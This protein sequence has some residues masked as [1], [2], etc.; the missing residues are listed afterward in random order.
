MSFYCGIDLGAR[1]SQICVINKRVKIVLEVKTSNKLEHIKRQ[2]AP[3]NADLR[4]SSPKR[5]FQPQEDFICVLAAPSPSV[6]R[7]RPRPD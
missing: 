3:Y 7:A 5:R 1:E 6:L 2:L 4:F